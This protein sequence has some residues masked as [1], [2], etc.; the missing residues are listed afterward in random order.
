MSALPRT[1]LPFDRRGRPLHDLRLSV[2]DA[3][4]FRCPYCMPAD[5]VGDHHGLDARSRLTFEQIEVLVR[6]F[7]RVGVSKLRLTGG[8]PLLRKGL[9]DLIARL[10][11]ID[12]LADLALTTN[13]ALLA[14]QAHALRHAGLGRLT[15]SLDALDPGLFHELSGR[16]GEISDVLSGL[17]AA[18]AA[19]FGPIKLNCVVQRGVNENEVL[20]LVAFAR[21]H[22]HL[23]RFIE[24]MDVGNCNGWSR[25]R[26]VP[27]A[28]LRDGIHAR[29]PIR[30]VAPQYRGEVASRYAFLDGCGEVGFV[31]SVSAPFCGDC[32]RARVSSDGL[33]YTC[34]FTGSGHDLRPLLDA[35]DTSV[36]DHVAALWRRRDDRYSESRAENRGGRKVEMFLI[37]G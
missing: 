22:G 15:V 6:G 27:S 11:R 12:G 19:G 23:M 32:N 36:A 8:E 37:G 21:E 31:S 17:A 3:C 25:G 7:V 34:L 13:G 30:P 10:S 29:W 2:I 28:E 1:E 5:R 18:T 9:P 4:N 33:L 24:Y 35:G 14:R 16:R 20:P 26:V